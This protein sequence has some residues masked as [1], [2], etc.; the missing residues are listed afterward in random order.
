VGSRAPYR[1]RP[2]RP[3]PPRCASGV[4]VAASRGPVPGTLRAHVGIAAECRG[5]VVFPS[6][7]P[8]G[9]PGAGDGS[10]A[11]ATSAGQQPASSPQ[12]GQ[13]A[14]VAHARRIL[15]RPSAEPRDLRDRGLLRPTCRGFQQQLRQPR[16]KSP[17]RPASERRGTSDR[18][19][20]SGPYQLSL[21]SAPHRTLGS[22]RGLLFQS[23]PSGHR[24]ADG[25]GAAWA[26]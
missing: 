6:R 18:A 7:P 8:A 4:G 13:L 1:S 3:G 11:L 17:S 12:P 24:S 22:R 9:A 21:P 15:E 14:A 20:V 2:F 19:R 25:R 5:Q 26:A 10:A 23:V 16:A